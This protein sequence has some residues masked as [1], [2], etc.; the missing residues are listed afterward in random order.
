MFLSCIDVDIHTHGHMLSELPLSVMSTPHAHS[1]QAPGELPSLRPSPGPVGVPGQADW[2]VEVFHIGNGILN[3]TA[4]KS[5]P[6]EF[7]GEAVHT[8][9]SPLSS[10]ALRYISVPEQHT[11]VYA[12]SSLLL[13]CELLRNCEVGSGQ[14]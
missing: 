5:G 3:E 14:G 13:E 8:L 11:L 4:Q 9:S 12:F 2:S 1:G 10:V 7:K 6:T